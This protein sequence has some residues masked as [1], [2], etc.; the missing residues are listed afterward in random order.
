MIHKIISAFRYWLC[1][2]LCM[3]CEEYCAWELLMARKEGWKVGYA[4]GYEDGKA[5][6]DPIAPPPGGK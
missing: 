5:G 3:P 2:H 6:R 1:R 4:L